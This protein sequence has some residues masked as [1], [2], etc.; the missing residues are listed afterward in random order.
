M[1]GEVLSENGTM[2]DLVKNQN[3]SVKPT[4]EEQTVLQIELNL[5]LA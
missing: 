3:F 1:E 4:Q 5:D 2:I